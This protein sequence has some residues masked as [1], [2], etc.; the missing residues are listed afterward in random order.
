[1]ATC[2][3][4]TLPAEPLIMDNGQDLIDMVVSNFETPDSGVTDEDGG[5]DYSAPPIPCNNNAHSA[6]Q[7]GMDT[8]M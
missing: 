6:V 5:H 3:Q 1:M 7:H 4:R 8:A 2:L